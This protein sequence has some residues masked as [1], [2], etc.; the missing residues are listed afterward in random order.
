M[1]DYRIVLLIFCVDQSSSQSHPSIGNDFMV[2][3]VCA[4]GRGTDLFMLL[5]QTTAASLSHL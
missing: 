4:T 3:V 1:R 5:D 2:K